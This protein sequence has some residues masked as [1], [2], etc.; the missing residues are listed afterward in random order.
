MSNAANNTDISFLDG[1]IAMA[2]A[3]AALSPAAQA[4]VEAER[5]GSYIAATP[6]ERDDA[7]IMKTWKVLTYR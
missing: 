5:A 7:A 4:A 2:H 3:H 6:T 1:L